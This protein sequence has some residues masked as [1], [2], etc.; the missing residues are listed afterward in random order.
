MKKTGF[1][2]VA[3]AVL[4]VAGAAQAKGVVVKSETSMYAGKAPDA[5]AKALLDAAMSQTEG[6]SWERIGV[7][8]V[9]YLGGKKSDAQTIFDQVLAG[10]HDAGDVYRIA[11]VY[12]EA[13]DWAKAKPMF[14]QF[15]AMGD[16]D[17]KE[18]SEIGAYYL[19]NG[20][21]ATAESYFQQAIARDPKSTWASMRMAG[22]YLGVEPQP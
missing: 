21:R 19:L 10:K 7:G 18:L 13:H 14:D 15:L 22:A 12:A 8:R 6:G 4:L 3:A 5:A 20:D 9:L 2:A 1:V 11:R 17:E 16:Y